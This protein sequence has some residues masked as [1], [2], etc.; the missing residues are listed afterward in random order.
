MSGE[1]IS[2]E[3]VGVKFEQL[4]VNELL[5]CHDV[6]NRTGHEVSTPLLNIVLT[7]LYFKLITMDNFLW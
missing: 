4:S 5:H 2:T 1:A 7:H 3:I 6:A